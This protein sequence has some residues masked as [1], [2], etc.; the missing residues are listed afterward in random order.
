M[1][2][3]VVLG[4]LNMDVSIE[5]DRIPSAGE[6]LEGRDLLLGPG[7]KGA[8]QAVASARMGA[9]TL[10]IGSV[11]SDLFGSEL[12]DS[13]A[14]A[15]V[16]T[17]YI[18]REAG[19]ATGTAVVIRSSGDNRIIVSQGANHSL[20][21]REVGDALSVVAQPDDILLT[22]LECAPLVVWEAIRHAKSLGMFVILNP[23]P[24]HAI[25]ADIL[26]QVDLLCLNETECSAVTGCQQ[27]GEESYKRSLEALIE[28]G[29]KRAV[30]TLGP[31]GSAA[32]DKN[33]YYRIPAERV[34]AVDT[35]GAGDTFVGTLSA[36]LSR[37]HELREAMEFATRA[38]ALATT[39]IGAQ[40][41][42][43]TIEEVESAFGKDGE[44]E[45]DTSNN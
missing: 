9:E 22:Q 16:S 28:G 21:V 11:G 27:D 17:G 19:D 37:G 12:I 36:F 1:S 6:T 30:L 31:R 8:N 38:A 34:A 40:G 20:G 26:P 7:G 23:S 13:L 2:K 4:S 42:I 41:S 18:K 33:G 3:V 24:A 10:M 15:G 39:H 43:P 32:L 44:N 25:P 29:A 5:A 14:H 35:T 45:W